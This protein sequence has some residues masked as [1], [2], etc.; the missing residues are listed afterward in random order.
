MNNDKVDTSQTTGPFG[1]PRTVWRVT[2]LLVFLLMAAV[3]SFLSLTKGSSVISLEQ[4]VQILL[5]PG[6]DP[7]S[8]IIW[9]IRMPRTIVG[10]LVGVNLALS[11][12]ILQ[13]VMRNPL[14]DPHIIGISSGAGLAGVVIM[15]LFPAMEYLITPVAFIGAMLA[16]VARTA[17]QN[18]LTGLEFASGIPG[19]IGGAVV[20][21]AGAY[22]GEMKHVL[23][24]V[25]V[26]T[27]EGEVL[28]I[29]AKALELGYRTSVI[30][31][32]GWIVLGT[33]L[34]LKK[35]DPEQILARMEELKEQRITKQPLDLPSAGSTF[36]RPEGYFAGKL[37][38][39]AGLRGF[40]VGGAQ[41][42]E[43]H[44]GFVVNRGNATA[45][46]VWE[47]IC[48]VKRRVKEMTGVELEPE[49]KLLGDFPQR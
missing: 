32:N 26:L 5:A 23:R 48:E 27:K 40:T 21:N 3:G 2:V 39:D 11:G 43:K 30:P 8:Q 1:M 37:I 49:V 4:I 44:C 19:T 25:T 10:A 6:N 17:Y 41:V 47:L 16:A 12:A 31:K 29:P 18:G 46:D 13:A 28:A 15:I 20:M 38:M 36:K 35:G 42:S 9:N 24:E 14:A 33:V 34:Q 7:Q 22:G 45:A